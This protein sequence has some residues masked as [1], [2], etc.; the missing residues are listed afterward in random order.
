MTMEEWIE[1]RK[2]TLDRLIGEYNLRDFEV[3]WILDMFKS[4]WERG[5]IEGY[6]E[7]FEAK[8]RISDEMAFFKK[9]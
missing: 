2:Q 9:M 3:Q 6:M 5:N 7:A 4:A 8:E 1:K